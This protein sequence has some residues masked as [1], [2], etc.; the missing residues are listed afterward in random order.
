MASE[1]VVQVEDGEIRFFHESFFDYSFARSFLRAN[2]D[3]VRWLGSDQQHL[4]RRSQVRQVLTFLRDRE[5]DWARYLQ[6]LSALLGHA[7][8]RF[9]IKKLVLDWLHALPGPTKEEWD[10]VEGLV[11]QLHGHTWQVVSN[12]VPWFDVLQTTA[13]WEAWLNA[14]EE[15]VNRTVLLLTMPEVLNA[16]SATV[17]SLVG[18]FRGRST[19][20]RLRLR[21]L[22][23]VGQ[24]YTSPEM[25]DLVIALIQDGTL[26]TA[27]GFAVN[28]DWWSV[29]YMTSTQEPAFT[30]RVLG[31]WFDRQLE[32]AGELT[33]DDPFSGN[34]ELVT[35][36]QFS[37][38]VITECAKR[39]PREFTRE[40]FPRF[41]K[42]D[43]RVPKEWIA[44][45]SAFGS[46][47]DQLRDALVEA[48]MSLAI[49]DPAE[50][51]SIM[52]AETLSDT[53]WMDSLVLRTWSSNPGHYGEHIVRYLMARP[54]KRLDIGYDVSAGGADI[55]AAVSRT[56]VASASASCSDASFIE[57]ENAICNVL[58]DWE[59]ERGREGLT[60]LV[61]LRALAQE[62]IGEDARQR[63]QELERRYP[64]APQ[65]GAPQPH[66]R[67]NE[68]QRVKAP[69][70]EE[71]QQDMTDAQ[72]LSAMAKHTGES[73]TFV[74]EQ[75]V[76]GAMELSQDLKKLVAK[77]PERFSALVSQMEATLRATYFEAILNGLTDNGDGSGRAGTLEQV[78]SVLRRIRDLGV[79][80]HGQEV[81]WAIRA[82]AEETIP[83]DIVEMLCRVAVDDRDPE[84]DDWHI[85]RDEES[86][87]NQAINTARGAAA[88]ALGRLL[89]ADRSRWGTLKPTIG[90]L[91][92]DRVLAVRSVA[93]ESLLAIL[94]TQRSDALT[95][96]KRLAKDAGPI[97]GTRYVERFLHYAIFRDYPAVR[98][99]LM[100]MLK[101]S[102]PH[103]VK[104]A[105]RQIAVAALWVEE[106][107]GDE[108]VVLEMVEHAR[109]GAATVY[110]SN[111]SDETVGT[112]CEK[113]LRTL[114]EDKSD[115]VRG[116]A[117]RCW[118]HLEP[119]QVASR[120]PL[121]D[122]FAHSLA[123][124]RDASLLAYRL[125]DARRPLPAE[126]CTLAE[127]AL[128]AFGSKAASIQN[129]EAG[130]AGE[131]AALMVR[132]HEQTNDPVLRE[133]ILTIIDQMIR[134]GSYGIDDQLRQQYDR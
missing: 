72:W 99:T 40:M 75:F 93:V 115:I 108:V 4:F 43:K 49:T 12:S 96:F 125:K 20:W 28:S 100:G 110:V 123:S 86:P 13:R 14:D 83:D 85:G 17:A 95:Y 59:R 76:G 118:V 36:S 31:A 107:R 133:R 78:C 27:A 101:S 64:N 39:A 122:A 53:K 87:I 45:P 77:Y 11:E 55:F 105:A 46:P 84:S 54:D 62:R 19:N 58:P 30:A 8:I 90:Q 82:L 37:D 73:P 7:V 68:A 91:V 119:D 67:K 113:H 5:S 114:F 29:W 22:V 50:L 132:L 18:P 3:L 61:L 106:A 41:A 71:I 130:F 103:V 66:T 80:V 126:L 16:R 128:E 70:S 88:T 35:Y 52:G 120:G 79:Q 15:A 34:P 9:H 24:R 121:I 81:A 1:A 48:M 44:G 69:I 97:L 6:T 38:H 104:T 33:R 2:S 111:L 74:E 112:E 102:E 116:E 127:R 92:E 21:R 26:D 25:E 57:L 63:I 51:D 42:F 60:E 32:R 56:A 10:I 134:L 117:S 47:D 129:E 94:D 89:F 124:A 131:L 65:R 98:P 23:E 109:A